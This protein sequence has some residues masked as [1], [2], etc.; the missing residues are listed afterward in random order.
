MFQRTL[1][2]VRPLAALA[3]AVGF[4][5]A[6]P[7]RAQSG[8]PAPKG[9]LFVLGF[10]GADARTA[11]KLMDE[12]S[13]PNL[14]RLRETGTFAPLGTT[15][16]AESP[17]SWAALN[18][19][20]NPAKTGIPGFV[21]RE[22]G[23]DGTPMPALGHVTHEKRA[24]TSFALPFLEG[25][26]IRQN[27]W[28]L[29]GAVGV[30]AALLF[31]GIFAGLLK[32]RARVAVPIALILGAVGGAGARISGSYVPHSIADVVGNPTKS[33]PFWEEA[34]KAGV[35]CV[36]IDSAMSWDRPE[37][38][39]AR[40]LSGLGVPDVRSNNG[41]WFVYTTDPKVLER[42]PIG[43]PTSTA[44]RIFRVDERDSVIESWVYGP[45]DFVAIDAAQREVAA[46]DARMG[47][48]GQS[49]ADVE[50]LRKRK[51]DLQSEVLPRLQVQGRFRASD[52]GRVSLPLKVT[53][54]PAG[55]A[56]VE[57]GAQE[58]VLQEGEW[59]KWYHLTFELSPLVK[60]RAIT[61]AKLVK[62]SEPFEL[63]LDFLQF[64]PAHPAWWQPVSQPPE[65]AAE[66]ARAAGAPYETVGWACLTMPF[67]DREIDPV[68]FL[69]DIEATQRSRETL[70]RAALKQTDWRGLMF[71]ESTPDR[72]QH[73]MYQF[74]DPTH[75]AYDAAKAARR[76]KFFGEDIALSDA[77]RASYQSMDRVVGEV[78]KDHVK[79]GDT[80]LVCA[81]HGFQS[82]K[83]QVHVNNWLAQEGYLAVLPDATKADQRALSFVDWSRTKAYAVGLGGIYLNLQGR[84]R[85]GTVAPKDAPALLAE[86]KQKLL[87]MEDS[88]RRA[89]RD[90]YVIS[91]IHSGPHLGE[92][93]DLMVGF[94]AGWR[95][96]WATTLGDIQLVDGAKPG[97]FVAGGV[98]EDNRLNWS[99]DHVSVAADLV[100]G[101]FF[102]NRKV[103]VPE[104]G[105][106]LLHIA[107][108]ALAV[109][110]VAVPPVY[111]HPPLT[112][113]E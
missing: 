109:L 33:A 3:L 29:A 76:T 84:E 50:A 77:I 1:L 59:S 64:D 27:T 70:L 62:R 34:A 49:S 43:Q 40:V 71:V 108:T 78:L 100:R 101:V 89:V 110:G 10:D 44:G 83:R 6:V 45:Y 96:S 30:G 53:L 9:R 99:G 102:S 11:A 14:A 5:F 75:P 88:G 47:K 103:V 24:S 105:I 23:P 8:G 60:V 73:M 79:P 57:I 80:L 93:P 16:P 48:P 97:T 113:R 91:E 46:I 90:V 74:A 13:L 52:E 68:T 58:Q 65:F 94:D 81:D 86:I 72:V 69:E 63:F 104:G 28:V 38:P 106:D 107:P 82:F 20:Q 37:V 21:K 17:V 31:L 85:D 19:G 111:D 95:V 32:I 25:L 35:P 26:L 54:E 7:A 61:R 42:A 55:G 98:F 41:D 87:A 4:L 66:L 67:K 22:L 39:G 2:A 56:R 15:M 112:F 51:R 36:V 18:S 12:G 92:E